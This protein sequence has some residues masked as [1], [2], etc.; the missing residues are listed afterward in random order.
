[1]PVRRRARTRSAPGRARASVAQRLEA[2]GGHQLGQRSGLDGHVGIA[3]GQR[4]WRSG[5]AT[6]RRGRRS[7]AAG[8]APGANTVS[9]RQRPAREAKSRFIGAVGFVSGVLEHAGGG[10]FPGTAAEA[11]AGQRRLR[12]IRSRSRV[13]WPWKMAGA[14]HDDDRRLLRPPVHRRRQ[15]HHIVAS[16]WITTVSGGTS[17]GSA[18][19]VDGP[20][21]SR[22]ERASPSRRRQRGDI[23]RRG[24][25]RPAPAG[26]RATGAAITASRSSLSPRPSSCAC[27]RWHRR[28]GSCGAPC[29]SP[30]AGRRGPWSAPP[31]CPSCRRTAGAD[32]TATTTPTGAS[33]SA[34]W[35]IAIS[36]VPTGP[37]IRRVR[38]ARSSPTSAGTTRRLT[39]LAVLQVRL[40]DLVDVAAV[41]EGVPGRVRVDHRDRAAGATV[42]A[43][44]LVDAHLPG[45]ARPAAL[46]RFLQWSKA[47]WASW[48]A[49]QDSPLSRWFRQKKWRWKYSCSWHGL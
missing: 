17:A 46:T 34:G 48:S 37:A 27:P 15:R 31:C 20:T 23:G 24:R 16:P 43:A 8:A 42:Q 25:S 12:T 40:D 19:R 7:R 26:V 38:S 36:I 3:R 33:R 6:H 22:R 35:S 14:G 32:G 5:R 45:P 18:S 29:A 47:A 4:L 30:S 49:Q 9:G 28:R 10:Q 11:Q 39:T 2:A 13:S 41:D 44:R 21:S 1:M